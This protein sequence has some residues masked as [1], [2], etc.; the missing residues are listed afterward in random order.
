MHACLRLCFSTKCLSSRRYFT[1]LDWFTDPQ[2][3]SLGPLPQ[4]GCC[5]SDLSSFL[6]CM[7]AGYTTVKPLV[8]TVGIKRLQSSMF[9]FDNACISYVLVFFFLLFFLSEH[10]VIRMAGLCCDQEK[11][12]WLEAVCAADSDWNSAGALGY[13]QASCLCINPRHTHCNSGPTGFQ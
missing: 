5:E 1:R 13:T 4:S 2:C 7:R 6:R 8:S 12:S 9:H 10:V 3:D 11:V